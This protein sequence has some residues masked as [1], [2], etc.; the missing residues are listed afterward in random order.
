MAH[1]VKIIGSTFGSDCIS[2]Y[3][4]YNFQDEDARAMYWIGDSIYCIGKNKPKVNGVTFVEHG[5]QFFAKLSN[6]VLWVG[7]EVAA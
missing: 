2:D 6:T 3:R 4:Y 1:P 5:D 7:T